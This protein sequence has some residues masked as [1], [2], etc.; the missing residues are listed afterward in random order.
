MIERIEHLGKLIHECP[1]EGEGRDHAIF[2]A[3]ANG[4]RVSRDRW[5]I[6]YATRGFRF[7]DD[8]RSIV[9]QLRAGAPGGP[10]IR[11]G[12]LSR[13]VDDWDP[14]N[15]GAAY[16][17]QHGHPVAF[18]MPKGVLI[19]GAP[20]PNANVFAVKWRVIA[21]ENDRRNGVSRPRRADGSIGQ[22]TQA[23]EW[24]QFRLNDAEDG[25]EVLQPRRTLRQKGYEEGDAFCER[26][27]RFMNQTFVQAVPFNDDCT[28]WADVNHFDDLR[29]APLRY[30]FNADTGL[31]E[32]AETGPLMGGPG[33][34]VFEASLLRLCDGWVVAARRCGEGGPAWA[35]TEDLF[36]G[37]PP[38]LFAETP[39]TNAPLTAYMCPDGVVRLFSGDPKASAGSCTR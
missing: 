23:V 36:G 8:D 12:M 22:R 26:T 7:T 33:C 31:Y 27:V 6:P 14:F 32:W 24:L 38:F 18:G 13:S 21:V 34:P 11:E 29:L 17:R 2:P 35:R 1:L 9:Y 25:I 20:A 15:E 4:L 3:H 37:A 16:T 39:V 30:H 5:F 28:E 10:V 19:S